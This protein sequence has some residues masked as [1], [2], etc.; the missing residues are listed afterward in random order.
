MDFDIGTLN[1]SA[2]FW[3][4]MGLC[5]AGM[6]LN[7]LIPA[8]LFFRQFPV[9]QRTAAG[10][11]LSSRLSLLIA[12]S[13]IAAQTG[14]LSVHLQNGFILL[15]VIT[16]FISPLLFNNT[17][18]NNAVLN[19]DKTDPPAIITI[20]KE[21]LPDGWELGQLIVRSSRVSGKTIRNLQLPQSI[22]IVSIMRDNE[23]IVPRGQTK[24][25]LLDIVQVMGE[26]S[27]IYKLKNILE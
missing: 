4:A 10:F 6:F 14:V 2:G 11:L 21:T 13:Q 7:K 22:L 15:A 26:Q 1:S 27:E 3:A 9:E 23:R 8:Q 5:L 20:N 12:A 17:M 24:L 25:E 16:C 18:D 19:N